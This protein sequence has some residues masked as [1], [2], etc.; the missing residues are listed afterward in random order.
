MQTDRIEPIRLVEILIGFFK[1][2]ISNLDASNN[3]ELHASL[4]N[5]ATKIVR[6]IPNIHDLLPPIAGDDTVDDYTSLRMLSQLPPIKRIILSFFKEIEYVLNPSFGD[7]SYEPRLLNSI[8]FG[9][10][11]K[12]FVTYSTEKGQFDDSVADSRVR[13]FL[14]NIGSRLLALKTVK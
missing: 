5:H 4:L 13:S 6:T 1:E 7:T 2:Y 12:I 14:E 3:I 8:L 11:G 9:V 10:I